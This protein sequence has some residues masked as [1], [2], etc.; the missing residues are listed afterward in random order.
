MQLLRPGREGLKRSTL[1]FYLKPRPA[2]ENLYL[3]KEISL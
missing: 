3:Y 1:P 2:G